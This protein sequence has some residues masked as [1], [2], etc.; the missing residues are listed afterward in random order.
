ML[1]APSYACPLHNGSGKIQRSR[2]SFND[3]KIVD[4]SVFDR[5]TRP[6]GVFKD[7]LLIAESINVMVIC[8][9]QATSEASSTRMA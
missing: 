9:L 2:I 3:L 1:A 4:A 6:I 8:S 7:F 5:C